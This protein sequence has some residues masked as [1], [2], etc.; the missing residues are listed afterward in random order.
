MHYRVIFLNGSELLSSTVLEAADD[1]AAIEAAFQ[2]PTE[3]T[4]FELWSES[5]RLARIRTSLQKNFPFQGVATEV[6]K[7]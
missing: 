2:A 5:R 6:N 7:V 1:M 3:A 4:E